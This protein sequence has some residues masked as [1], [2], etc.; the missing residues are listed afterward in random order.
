MACC[1][2]HLENPALMLCVYEN[3]RKGNEHSWKNQLPNMNSRGIC[4]ISFQTNSEAMVSVSRD[5]W[6]VTNKNHRAW[7][8]QTV[9]LC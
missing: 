9:S 7:L 3:F 4:T 2:P 6:S 5:Q 8:I 1:S